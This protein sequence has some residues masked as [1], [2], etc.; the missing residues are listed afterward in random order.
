MPP[1]TFVAETGALLDRLGAALADSGSEGTFDPGIQA[2]VA[3]G[4]DWC[5]ANVEGA[6]FTT[7]WRIFSA[8]QTPAPETASRGIADLVR[9]LIERARARHPRVDP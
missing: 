6:A 9:T 7:A 8:W 4:L 3:A 5:S 1:R 2:C